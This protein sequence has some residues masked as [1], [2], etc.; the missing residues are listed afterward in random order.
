[1]QLVR[2]V[3]S[4]KALRTRLEAKISVHNEN[5]DKARPQWPAGGAPAGRP[6]H[7]ASSHMR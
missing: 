5:Q 3:A 7:L 4:E 6:R 2:E 1:M